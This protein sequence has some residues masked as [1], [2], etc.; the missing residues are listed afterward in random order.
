MISALKSVFTFIISSVG[1]V[2]TALVTAGSDGVGKGALYDLLPL[3]CIGVAVSLFGI[4]FKNIRRIC[5]GA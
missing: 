2:V 3:F 1:E 4:C 5:W